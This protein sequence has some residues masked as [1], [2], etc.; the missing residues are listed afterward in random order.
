MHAPGA[1]QS[2]AEGLSR[3]DRVCARPGSSPNRQRHARREKGRLSSV[4][5]LY[6]ITK[7][8]AA[9]REFTRAMRD[10]TGNLPPL[11]GIFPDYMAPIVRNAPDGVRELAMLRWG[12][13]GPAIGDGKTMSGPITLSGARV[14][15]SFTYT[16]EAA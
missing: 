13:P 6:G 3:L 4:C 15:G 8:Q 16:P 9:I 1:V 5:N 7:G 11:P 2:L 12:M 14:V 10:T